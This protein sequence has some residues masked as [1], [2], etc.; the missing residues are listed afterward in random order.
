MNPSPG[1]LFP[2][3]ADASSAASVVSAGV[4]AAPRRTLA[5]GRSGGRSVVGSFGLSVG[6]SAVL[7]LGACQSSNNTGPDLGVADLATST[8]VDLPPPNP[9]A[10]TTAFDDQFIGFWGIKAKVDSIQT[11]PVFGDKGSTNTILSVGQL[12]RDGMGKLVMD[13]Q[14]CQVTVKSEVAF[15]MTD[16]PDK[17]ADTTPM[18]TGAV[19]VFGSAGAL[20]FRRD[21]V[22]IGIG[23]NLVEPFNDPLPTD[24]TDARVFDQDS[25]TN[26]GVTVNPQSPVKGS[27]YVVQRR[28]YS[29]ENGRQVNQNRLTG[30]IMDRSSQYILDATDN[31]LKSQVPTKPV[32]TTSVFEMIRLSSQYTCTRLKQEAATL[33]TLQ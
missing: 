21:Q 28:K 16:V 30:S 5:G 18:L 22:A 10:V 24:K 15:I 23:C 6:L 26:P 29:Y 12:R 4:R 2:A 20:G 3:G 19:Q 33:F 1:S 27:V 13:Q 9:D 31:A 8:V 17:I 7:A 11:L 32:D 25:D 14:E